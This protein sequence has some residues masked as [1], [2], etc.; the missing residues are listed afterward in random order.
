VSSVE[1][2]A[3]VSC[4]VGFASETVAAGTGDRLVGSVGAETSAVICPRTSTM[5]AIA[6][7]FDN[8]LFLFN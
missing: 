1:L 5:A 7:A 6:T 4:G 3:A 8:D 2:S